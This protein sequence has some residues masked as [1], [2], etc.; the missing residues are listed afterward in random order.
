MVK[1][2]KRHPDAGPFLHPVDPIALNVP[3]YL[4]VIKNPM[5]ISTLQTNL[6]SNKYNTKD[7]F[8]KDVQLIF[9]NCY[10]YNGINSQISEMAKSLEKVFDNML[11]KMPKE[12]IILFKH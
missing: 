7:E 8:I 10:T 12:V 11:K 5:D 6:N 2:L 9:S 4:D 3:D 1:A